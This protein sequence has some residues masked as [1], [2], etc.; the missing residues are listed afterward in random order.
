MQDMSFGSRM[1]ALDQHVIVAVG[2]SVHDLPDMTFRDWYADGLTPAE[3]F[4]IV[5][6]EAGLPV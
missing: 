1:A 5:K 6:D 2:L 3:A 4:D